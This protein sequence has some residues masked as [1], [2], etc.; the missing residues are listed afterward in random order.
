VQKK[1][2]HEQFWFLDLSRQT[3]EIFIN[4]R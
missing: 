4:Y 1:I 2:N 3:A